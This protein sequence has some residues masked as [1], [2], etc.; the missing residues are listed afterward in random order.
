MDTEQL[1]YEIETEN[2]YNDIITEDVDTL[3]DKCN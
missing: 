1:M 3:F 2:F